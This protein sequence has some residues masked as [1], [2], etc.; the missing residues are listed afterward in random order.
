M[1]GSEASGGC[2]CGQ[3]R[4]AIKGLP[5]FR[6][7]CHC[8]TCQAYNQADYGDVVVMRSKHVSLS[9]AEHIDF[10]FHQSPPIVKRGRCAD[11]DGVTVETADL[12]LLPELTIIPAQTLDQLTGM[13]DPAFH[14]YYNRRVADADDGLAKHSG[15]LRSQL[16]FGRALLGALRRSRRYA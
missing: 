8:Q 15:N 12:P 2:Q 7:Y 11:C 6:A 10:Q 1:S 4:Y 9:G 13:P 16:A 3:V 14:M 5:L